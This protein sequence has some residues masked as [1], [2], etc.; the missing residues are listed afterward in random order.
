MKKF[1]IRL[2]IYFLLLILSDIA[3][4]GV[5][6]LFDLTKGGQIHKVHT[7][8]TEISPEMLILG[9]SRASH[10]YDPRIIGDSLGISVFN[11]GCDG[12]GTTIAYGFLK[13]VS[14]RSYPKYIVCE[15]TPGFDLYDQNGSFTLN[16]LNPY[17]NYNEIRN[18]ILDFDDNERL[19]LI[20]NSYRLNSILLRLIPT[21]I[22][23]KEQYKNGYQPLS[24]NIMNN[25]SAK[26]NKYL[27]LKKIDLKEKY[28]R[29]LI[30]DASSHNCKIVFTISPK[31]H[32]GDSIFYKEE[33]DII[34]EY[35]IP[36]VNRLNDSDIIFNQE[37]FQDATHM[38]NIGATKYTKS[39]ITDLRKTFN[40]K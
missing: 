30:E 28:L 23:D 21:I 9:S 38:N 36:I 34:R 35:K 17:I 40:L 29:K 33:L 18:L 13:G 24:G 25:S 12:Q 31:Y 6:K 4:G 15:I 11:A 1:I 26:D 8:M 19:K 3:L 37:F 7:I 20:S 14:Q 2:L 16:M 39:I 10:H 5:Y 27:N 32:G 22:L